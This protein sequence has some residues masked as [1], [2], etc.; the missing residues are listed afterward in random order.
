M[1]TPI[2][3]IREES[4]IIIKREK[5]SRDLFSAVVSKVRQP[6]ESFYNWLNKKTN[7]QRAIK[8]QIYIRTFSAYEG[9]IAIVFI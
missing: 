8:V 6:I 5:V 4:T 7:I 2:K 3:T 1:L 9:E